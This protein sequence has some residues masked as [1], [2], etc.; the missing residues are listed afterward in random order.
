MMNQLSLL[1]SI[2]DDFNYNERIKLKNLKS[3][4]DDEKFALPFIN[5]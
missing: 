5:T 4:R 2:T 1:L 3:N